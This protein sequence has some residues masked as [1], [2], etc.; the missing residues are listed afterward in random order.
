MGF[1]I[2]RGGGVQPPDRHADANV[3]RAAVNL[4][5]DL[6]ALRLLFQNKVLSLDRPDKD[7]FL[8][9][10]GRDTPRD[11]LEQPERDTRT[12]ARPRVPARWRAARSHSE[13]QG[14]NCRGA[15]HDRVPLKDFVDVG[16]MDILA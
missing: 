14:R 5:D 6:I 2:A 16:Y 4:L 7:A 12:S 8:P 1:G 9:D 11:D 3:V 13:P 15:N 10:Q